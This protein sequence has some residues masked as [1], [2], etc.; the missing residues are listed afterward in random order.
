MTTDTDTVEQYQDALRSFQTSE[1]RVKQIVAGVT[2]VANKLKDWPHVSV[3]GVKFGF[4]TEV[5]S[6]PP[7]ISPNEWPTLEEIAE[8]L[9]TWHSDRSIVDNAWNAIPRKEGLQP[10]S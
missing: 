3:D 1:R 4:P 10:P 2:S 9:S 6:R 8:A 7:V 5:S